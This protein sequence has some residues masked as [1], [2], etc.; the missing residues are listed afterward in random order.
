MTFQN[1]KTFVD[2][3]IEIISLDLDSLQKIADEG[4]AASVS[5]SLT[6]QTTI[7]PGDEKFYVRES[8]KI[9]RCTIPIAMV[10]FSVVD[11]F[12][13]WI[14]DHKDDDFGHSSSA[15]FQKLA[16]KDDLKNKDKSERLK[17]AFRHG[18]MH[19]FFARKGF[20]VTYPFYE[21][22]SLFMDITSKG[23]TL[24]VRYLL[25]I[26][27]LGIQNLKAEL[28]NEQSELSKLA[29]EGYQRWQEK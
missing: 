19:S 1:F 16:K 2:E 10:C 7:R 18:I 25:K 12:G 26:V 8:P 28:T 17:E 15:F 23:S 29:F 24:D 27:R 5:S 21:N 6:T 9:L 14:N 3:T 13:Q 22:N 4:N 11:M 20:S